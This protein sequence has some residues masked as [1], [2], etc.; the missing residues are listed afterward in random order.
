MLANPNTRCARRS[1][2]NAREIHAK[3]AAPILAS[4]RGHAHRKEAKMATLTQIVT[5]D[6][7]SRAVADPLRKT[8]ADG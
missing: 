5:A 2:G 8:L 3:T 1:F 7:V 4:P 6:D